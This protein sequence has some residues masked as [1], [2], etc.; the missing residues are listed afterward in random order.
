[1][2]RRNVWSPERAVEILQEDYINPSGECCEPISAYKDQPDFAD[3]QEEDVVRPKGQI[4]L[5]AT[6]D[7]V[8]KKLWRKEQQENK[9]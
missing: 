5:S 6:D 7:N 3:Y 8:A 9:S 1:L 2:G 4:V